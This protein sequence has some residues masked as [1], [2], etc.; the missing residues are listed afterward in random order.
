M[1]LAGA[2]PAL[3]IVQVGAAMAALAACAQ[4]TCQMV[5]ASSGIPL[6]R[7]SVTVEGDLDLRGTLG[8]SRTARVGFGTPMGEMLRRYWQ[9][10]CLSAELKD[11]P[12][13][14]VIMG[15][16]LVAF[17]DPSGQVGVLD[18]PEAV[19]LRHG[20]ALVLEDG[21]LIEVVAAPEPLAEIRVA[22]PRDLA[23]MAWHLGNRHL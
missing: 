23:R 12:K 21:R 8:M 10:V 6:R 5:A 9:P 4:L 22:E 16:E 1:Q 14:L 15:E 2:P 11:L 20:D 3:M 18:L 17:R 19:V 7:V 13:K